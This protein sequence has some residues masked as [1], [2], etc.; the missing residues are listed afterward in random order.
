MTAEQKPPLGC[1]GQGTPMGRKRA[2]VD[3]GRYEVPA[4]QTER[5]ARL[6]ALGESLAPPAAPGSINGLRDAALAALTAKSDGNTSA[7]HRGA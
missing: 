4:D 6:T 3:G 5:V 7:G 2:L 1:A